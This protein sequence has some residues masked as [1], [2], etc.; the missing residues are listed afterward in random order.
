MRIMKNV[1]PM[2]QEETKIP[3][4]LK[5]EITRNV[6][7][8]MTFAI[9]HGIHNMF[10]AEVAFDD[11]A[12]FDEGE[13]SILDKLTYAITK[14]GELLTQMEVGKYGFNFDLE[15]V[16]LIVTSEFS[17]ATAED[18][19]L[20]AAFVTVSIPKQYI[21]YGSKPEKSLTFA[22][23]DNGSKFNMYKNG[24]IKVMVKAELDKSA[25]IPF[26][27]SKLAIANILRSTNSTVT[28][29]PPLIRNF[30]PTDGLRIIMVTYA[31]NVTSEEYTNF[32]D[33]VSASVRD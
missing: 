25:W 28:T 4:D 26:F 18:Y 8:C 23:S 7:G 29:C 9:R 13:V 27:E 20:F 31:K 12:K 14:Y 32:A 6:T 21:P 3:L 19:V 10:T 30:N 24:I 33:Y 11:D 15:D 2:I 1:K 5:F 22:V 16:R 17:N